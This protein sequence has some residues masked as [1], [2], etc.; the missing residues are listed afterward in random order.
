MGGGFQRT[1]AGITFMVPTPA[2]SSTWNAKPKSSV[3]VPLNCWRHNEKGEVVATM[4][5][6][7]READQIYTRARAQQL[8]FKK[9]AKVGEMK[10]NFGIKYNAHASPMYM[11]AIT[12]VQPQLQLRYP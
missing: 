2:M 6:L 5:E 4:L 11:T 3:P 9:G 12:V 1:Q 7:T 8:E 10:V